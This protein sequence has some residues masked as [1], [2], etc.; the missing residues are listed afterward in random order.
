MDDWKNGLSYLE[1]MAA[2]PGQFGDDE[3]LP[4]AAGAIA[5]AIKFARYLSLWG[6]PA[7]GRIC[8]DSDGGVLFEEWS[9]GE[10]LDT[11]RFSADGEIEYVRFIDCKIVASG[12]LMEGK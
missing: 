10:Q 6:V 9:K 4:P 8:T 11:L 3:Y 5:T 12:K 7:P 2:D 1:K